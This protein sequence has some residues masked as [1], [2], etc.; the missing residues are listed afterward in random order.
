MFFFL[1][2]ISE[3]EDE[4]VYENMDVDTPGTD[5]KDG[6][7]DRVS[8]SS[9]QDVPQAAPAAGAVNESDTSCFR[10]MFRTT[11]YRITFA[12]VIVGIMMSVVAMTMIILKTI[13]TSK[14]KPHRPS[15]WPTPLE[16]SSVSST[17]SAESTTEA[18]MMLPTEQSTTLPLNTTM[19]MV[20]RGLD[21]TES[22]G[23]GK[24]TCGKRHMTFS[25]WLPPKRVSLHGR[26]LRSKHQITQFK[27]RTERYR[28]STLP[29][30]VDLLNA[31]QPK[32]VLE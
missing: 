31:E 5:G 17:M 19:T 27:C 25:N 2:G 13:S 29:F 23:K 14:A 28:K 4:H 11:F 20:H 8:Q 9:V 12:I 26:N 1:L 18:T 32:T 10:R 6:N 16:E 22:P 21:E 15:H 24:H 7:V 30:L 3:A